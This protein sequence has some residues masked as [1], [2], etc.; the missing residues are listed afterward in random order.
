MAQEEEEMQMKSI[1]RR[2]VLLAGGSLALALCLGYAP[3]ASAGSGTVTVQLKASDGFTG[4]SGATVSYYKS[5]KKTLGTGTTDINGSC[6][7]EILDV[8]TTTIYLD[9]PS[10]GTQIWLAVDPATNPT[11][12]AQMVAVT[13]E[14]KTCANAPLVGVAKYYHG[15][16]QTIANTPA[17]IDLLPYTGLGP[18]QGSYDFLVQY[19]GRTSATIRQDISV[20]PAVLFKTTKVTLTGGSIWYYNG[21]WQSF[22]SPKELIGGPGKTADFK[23]GDTHNPTVTLPIEGCAITK[24][25][26]LAR[27]T[28]SKGVGVPGGT[29]TLGVGG[30]PSIGTTGADGWLVYLYDG[31]LGNMKVRMSAPNQGGTQESPSQNLAVNP[32]FNFQTS[33]ITIKLLNSAA[34][35]ADGGVVAINDGGWPVIGTTGDDGPGLIK[36]EHFLPYTRTFRM[37]FNYGTEFKTQDVGADPVVVFQ[38]GLVNLWF[39]GTTQHG[40]GGWPSYVKP[41]EMLPIA[42]RFAFSGPEYPRVEL[43]LTPTAGAVMEKTIGYVRVKNSAGA[44]VAGINGKWWDYGINVYPVFGPTDSSGIALIAMDGKHVKTAVQISS[45]GASSSYGFPNPATG[46]S[47]YDFQ[48]V[49][50]TVR[51]IDNTDA[52]IA[53]ATPTVYSHPYGGAEFVLGTMSGGVVS[54]DLMPGVNHYF[55]IKSYGF[56]GSQG[57]VNMTIPAAPTAVDIQTGKVVDDGFGCDVYQQYGGPL[58]TFSDG[59][60]LLPGTFFFKDTGANVTKNLTV[61]K[62]QTLNLNTGAYTTP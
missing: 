53:S 50:V 20:D 36:H 59:V 61:K 35:L 44:G 58:Q 45:R 9:P 51:L 38:T 3:P 43:L 7:G 15:G 52:V 10:G 13:I 57:G 39:T 22:I 47:F 6:S 62:G 11:L 46:N 12:D 1:T 19:E 32:V 60:Q 33:E 29:A 14:L 2:T 54:M 27:L 56:N 49:N 34:S 21:G 17:T 5:G 4:V 16:W 8:T 31:T 26:V 24:S 40:V 55:E 30:W 42:H 48:L 37:S 18:G 28:N 41:T 25:A 23:F